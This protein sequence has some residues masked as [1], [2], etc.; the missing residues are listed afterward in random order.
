M[1]KIEQDT[2][3]L[4]PYIKALSIVHSMLPE[5]SI[6]LANT[7]EWLVYYP[8][9]KINIGLKPGQRI[10]PK[11]PLADCIRNNERIEQDIPEE[12]FG[13]PFTGLAAPILNNGEV[14]GALAI[15]LQKQ[16]ERDLRNISEQ[17]VDSITQANHRITNISN[18]AE[19]LAE[20]THTLLEQSNQAAKEVH[21]TDDVLSFIKRI[22]DQTNL[23]GLNAAIEAARAGEKGA[24]FGVVANEIR[25]L[26]NETVSSTEKIRTI[27]NNIQKSMTDITASIDKVVR[28][29]NAQAESTEELSSFIVKIETMSKELNNY[30][31]KL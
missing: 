3:I 22:A 10:N 2:N 27:L 15:Q 7:E 12:L 18:S 19:G 13:I 17:I 8:G 1:T 29:G 31:L 20:I 24:G 11:E 28:V 4:T 6:G 23:L 21:N 9:N 30:A 16:N 25:K 5:L 14:I 26:S